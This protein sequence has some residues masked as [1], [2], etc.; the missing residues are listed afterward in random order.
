MDEDFDTNI[1]LL[2]GFNH[3][4]NLRIISH[5]KIF[6]KCHTALESFWLHFSFLKI[7]SFEEQSLNI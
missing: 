6:N 2:Q 4:T 5:F 3:D 1:K 7:I